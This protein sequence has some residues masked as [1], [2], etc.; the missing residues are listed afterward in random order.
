MVSNTA[1]IAATLLI[2]LAIVISPGPSFALVSR[3][4]IAGERRAAW[5]VTLGLALGGAFYAMLTMTGMA[6]LISQ[7]GGLTRA[8]QIAGGSYLLFLGVQTWRHAGSAMPAGDD[9]DPDDTTRFLVG[10]KRG[11][12]MCLS[13]PKAIAFFVGLY[14]AA[15]P[16]GT[17]LWAKAA[18]FGGGFAIELV[19][20]GMVTTMLSGR[21]VRALYQRCRKPFERAMG[22]VLAAFGVRLILTNA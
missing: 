15:I 13:N 21:R 4:A 17:A 19:W 18:V 5:G 14:A 2:Y 10:V 22:A 8:L 1:V 20:Y 11:L 16:A 9:T 7:I 3:T 6:V 12:L